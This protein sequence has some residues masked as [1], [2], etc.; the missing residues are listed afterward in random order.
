VAE[1]ER[2]LEN[3][4][5]LL[6]ASKKSKPGKRKCKASSTTTKEK[7]EKSLFFRLYKKTCLKIET[8]TKKISTSVQAS[9]A[10]QRS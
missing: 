8:T 7:E 3:D 4:D 2:T 6:A 10:L 1:I 5:V 9:S